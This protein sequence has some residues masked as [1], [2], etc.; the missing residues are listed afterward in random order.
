MPLNTPKLQTDIVQILTDLSMSED[1]AQARI[2][3]ARRMAAAIDGFVRSGLVTTTGTA[4]AQTGAI[5]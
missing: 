3:Y 5:T 2:D 1:P 4:A